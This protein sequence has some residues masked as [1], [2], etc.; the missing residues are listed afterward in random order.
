MKLCA[1]SKCPETLMMKTSLAVPVKVKVLVEADLPAQEAER[2]LFGEA[3]VESRKQRLRRI[4]V[5]V[6]EGDE[7]P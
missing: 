2:R 7:F 1:N 4:A 5:V 6:G 3:L